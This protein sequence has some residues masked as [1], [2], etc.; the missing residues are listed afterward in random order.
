MSIRYGDIPIQ[1][2]ITAFGNSYRTLLAEPATEVD[3][4]CHQVERPQL[5]CHITQPFLQV[6]DDNWLL[7]GFFV[8][9][10]IHVKIRK[11][12]FWPQWFR[13]KMT[14]LFSLQIT[15]LDIFGDLLHPILSH[16]VSKISEKLRKTAQETALTALLLQ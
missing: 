15:F 7:K 14:I 6:L 13:R 11:G 16:Q 8:S 1:I 12:N 9:S 5:I 2:L 4:I 10:L 3:I